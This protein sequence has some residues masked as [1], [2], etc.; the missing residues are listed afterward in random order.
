[1]NKVDFSTNDLK[2]AFTV[3]I[4][5][6]ETEEGLSHYF[7]LENEEVNCIEFLFFCTQVATCHVV[8][9]EKMFFNIPQVNIDLTTEERNLHELTATKALAQ[10]YDMMI[11]QREINKQIKKL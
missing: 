2:R 11:E 1:M 10:L 8:N 9:G 4:I 3:K 5:P 6:H 7:V